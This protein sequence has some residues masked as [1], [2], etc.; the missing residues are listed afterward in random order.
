MLFFQ[1]IKTT[2]STKYIY[3]IT[4][5]LGFMYY[6]KFLLL[7]GIKVYQVYILLWSLKET[8]YVVE[9]YFASQRSIVTAQRKFRQHLESNRHHLER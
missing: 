2:P 1:I 8:T 9:E 4:D 7:L 5:T 6:A 3:Y